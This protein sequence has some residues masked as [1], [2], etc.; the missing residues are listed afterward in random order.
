MSAWCRSQKHLAHAAFANLRDN[1]VDAETGAWREGQV[2]GYM[3]V[4]RLGGSRFLLS[5]AVVLTMGVFGCRPLAVGGLILPFQKH[6]S[7][8]RETTFR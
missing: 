3:A 1:L 4:R 2:V 6:L 7:A 5:N 8:E